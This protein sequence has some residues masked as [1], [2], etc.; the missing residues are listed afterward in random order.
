MRLDKLKNMKGDSFKFLQ[1]CSERFDLIFA[2]PPYDLDKIPL[3][4]DLVF[5]NDLLKADGLLVLEHP[6]D[7]TFGKHPHFLEHRKYGRVN[8][9]FFK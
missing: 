8:F 7:H 6:E 4:P 2:D 1:R 9:T 3:I 5:Q